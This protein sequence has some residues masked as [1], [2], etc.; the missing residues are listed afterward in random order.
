MRERRECCRVP[1]SFRRT[2][3]ITSPHPSWLLYRPRKSRKGTRKRSKR[4]RRRV[5][6]TVTLPK[7]HHRMRENAATYRVSITASKNRHINH[8]KRRLIVVC[9]H[10]S[11]IEN[12]TSWLFSHGEPKF[13]ISMP[14]PEGKSRLLS[15]QLFKTDRSRFR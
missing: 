12:S 10:T 1:F 13:Q 15:R 11:N 14:N 2:R 4:F 7:V 9:F 6:C 8:L 5:S 3:V